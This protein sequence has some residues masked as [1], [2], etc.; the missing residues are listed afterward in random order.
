MVGLATPELQ[1]VA[2]VQSK[3]VERYVYDPY[4]KTYIE[5][6]SATQPP[7]GDCDPASGG[8]YCRTTEPAWLPI[9]AGFRYAPFRRDELSYLEW[10][11]I[12]FDRDHIRIA[13]EKLDYDWRPKRTGRTMD[14]HPALRD[15][16]RSLPR[17]SSFV[18]TH[19]DNASS[20][21]VR[22]DRRELGRKAWR[23]CKRICE[24]LDLEAR[25]E[26]KSWKRRFPNGPHLKAFRSGISI[27]LQISGAPL[28][29]CQEMLGHHDARITLEHYTH[30][31]PELLG[32]L[33]TKFIGGLG[34]DDCSRK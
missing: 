17:T 11:D 31:A 29:Y 16:L 5:A 26:T 33:T 34:S 3:L 1:G 20:A 19:P 2:G 6:W 32:R 15:I 7:G 13:D 14:M 18:Y 4:G 12:E 10:S 27:E 25:D 23:K 21:K 24:A 28:A 9:F 22:A 8:G 30:I